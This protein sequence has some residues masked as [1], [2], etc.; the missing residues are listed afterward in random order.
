MELVGPIQSIK[1][2]TLD[3]SHFRGLAINSLSTLSQEVDIQ[4]HVVYDGNSVFRGRIL[5]LRSVRYKME[6]T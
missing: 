4:R 2:P 5:T 1:L 6:K 3:A